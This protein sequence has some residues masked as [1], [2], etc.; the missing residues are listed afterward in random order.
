MSMAWLAAGGDGW[1]LLAPGWLWL[2]PVLVLVEGLLARAR[3]RGRP[4]LPPCA[5]ALGT[6]A[7]APRVR[8]PGLSRGLL[9]EP[10]PGTPGAGT[11]R[12]WL[13]RGLAWGAL[14]GTILALAQPVR[15]GTPLPGP[16]PTL[17][18]VLLVDVSTAMVLEDYRVDDRPVRRLDVLVAAIRHL[19]AGLPGSRVGLVAYGDHAQT[20]V[21]MTA[22]HDL[23]LAALARLEPGVAGRRNAPGEALAQAVARASRHRAGAG[24]AGSPPVLILLSA[25]SDP[26]GE[27]DPLA[28]AELVREA[29]LTLHTIAI[30]A[31]R[32]TSA[33]GDRGG[34]V[35]RPAD[36]GLLEAMALRTGGRAWR[37]S[38]PRALD[39]ALADIR[40]QSRHGAS[41]STGERTLIHG[42]RWPA[43]LALGLLLAL[44]LTARAPRQRRRRQP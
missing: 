20:L 25:G 22:D 16:P 9:P 28:G 36:F 17:D 10:G 5:L 24:G 15:P 7:A 41:A 34:L 4:G 3:R 35:Y 40:R 32:P 21:P 33:A 6:P 11:A 26:T 8:H 37:A 27:V 44:P 1:T 18:L 38:D 13:R 29:G 12:R 14:L 30:G 2:I 19:L 31:H 43:A 39:R 42:Y 23:V